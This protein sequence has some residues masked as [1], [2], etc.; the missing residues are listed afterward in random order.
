MITSP[1]GATTAQRRGRLSSEVH[2]GQM[3][4]QVVHKRRPAGLLTA[5]ICDEM[6]TDAPAG[7]TQALAIDRHC[8]WQQG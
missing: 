6:K 8:G 5:S 1:I 2:G 4:P 3:A 7:V